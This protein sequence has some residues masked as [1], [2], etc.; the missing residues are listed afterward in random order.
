MNRRRV[1]NVLFTALVWVATAIVLIPLFSI[2]YMVTANGITAINWDFFTQLPVPVGE[3]GGGMGNA[4][5]GTL[6][7][8]GIAAAVGVPVGILAGVYLAEYGKGPFAQVV[9]FV[10][11][12]LSGAP[13]IIVGIFIYALIVVPMGSFSALA[14]GVA[15]GVLMIPTITRTTEEMLNLVPTSI[16]EASWALGIPQWKTVLRVVLPTALGGIM[17]GV[18]LSIARAAG[19]TAPLLFTALNNR[20][21]HSSLTQPIASLPVQIFTYAISPFD[22][23]HRQA[24]A[25]SFVLICIVLTTSILTRLVTRGR[26]LGSR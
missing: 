6:I 22:D 2:L 8:V 17:T 12:V 13:S 19:E 14:G 18:M 5:V 26:S 4:I 9:R 20:F 1:A 23:W 25:A 7:L 3:P 21:W 15:L 10:T 24:W 16:R 11:D